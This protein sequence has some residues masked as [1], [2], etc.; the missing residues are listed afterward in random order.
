MRKYSRRLAVVLVNLVILAVL[1]GL[2]EWIF[3]A[4]RYP[5]NLNRLNLVRGQTL[6]FDPTQLYNA[7]PPIVEYRRDWFG[8]RGSFN[9]PAE[10]DILTVGG[11]TTD[12][13]Y[14][15]EGETWQDILQARFFESG[16]ELVLGNAGV[17]GQ[18]T[19]GHLKNFD[20]W[21]PEIPGLQPRYVLYYVGLNDLYVGIEGTEYDQI[22]GSA[23]AGSFLSEI[24]SKSAIWHL[25][26]TIRG[27]YRAQAVFGIGHRSIDFSSLLWTREPML[28]D[29]EFLNSSL[30]G[31]A[32]R[33]RLLVESTRALGAEPIFVS[34]PLRAFRWIGETLEGCADTID[35]HGLSANGID[36][37][38]MY[39]KL[40]GVTE[41]I[42][43]EQRV[44]FF[45]L[46]STRD[47]E[48]TDFYD[49]YHMTPKGTR[50]VGLRM[51]D[52]LRDTV[53][54]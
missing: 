5:A 49:F 50:K 47:W 40:D 31:Y 37:Y 19:V 52:L 46:G 24:R 48:Q 32:A 42:S 16:I 35:F 51:F 34:Q 10:I 44:N 41:T 6:R 15:G 36:L 18:S 7:N 21:F 8:L 9:D 38:R 25:G 22:L 28:S 3:G 27:I 26:R 2:I 17:D 23:P 11:S 33:L 13:R 20:W 45:D 14:V 4:W 29:Y 12:Q 30:D 43:L 39:R 53:S 54:D 1:L